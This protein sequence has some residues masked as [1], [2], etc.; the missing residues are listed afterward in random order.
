MQSLVTPTPATMPAPAAAGRTAT[1]GVLIV[2][3]S[4]AIARAIAA[5]FAR[6]GQDVI[7]AGRDM[8]DLEATAADLR[9]RHAVRA[10]AQ[11]FDALDFDRHAPFF[12]T[13]TTM[14]EGGLSGIV[15]CHGSLPDQAAAEKDFAVARQAIDTNFT[16]AASILSIA[17]EYFETRGKGF[18]C[19]L[20]SVAGDRGR[21]SNYVYGA[22]KGG[23]TVFLQGLHQRLAKKHIPVTTVKPGFVDTAMTWGLPKLFLV[24]TPAAV[25]E[26]VFRA[27]PR[28]GTIYTPW[29]WWGIM[30]LI[31]CVPEFI[32]KRAKL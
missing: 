23:L 16:S 17:A 11:S 18:L 32:F 10:A 14:L 15:V 12:N 30:T 6:A 8:E 29:F 22:A 3:A 28:G 19:C 4:S 31:K 13:C 1:G 7:L 9:T 21:Q 2:G 24:A 25:A 20:S 5:R 26:D 27:V